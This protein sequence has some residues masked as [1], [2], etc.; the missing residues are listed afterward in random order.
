MLLTL[1][2]ALMRRVRFQLGPGL[3]RPTQLVFVPML[4]LTP[5][6]A[7][8]RWW[9]SGRSSA[10]CPSSSRRRAHPERLLVIVADGWYSVG[11][12]LVIA[13]L[14]GGAAHDATWGV[15]RARAGG[16]DRLRPRRL[17]AAR[18]VRRGDLARRAAAGA[19]ARLPD[20]RAR[21]PRSATSPCSPSEVHEYAYLLAI[22]PGA[23][24]GLIARERSTRI[25]HELA[26]ERAFRRSTRALDARADGPAPPG[27]PAAAA[28]PPRG[29]DRRPRR[30]TARRSSACCST[31][32]IEAL[33]AD[34][35]RL[36]ELDET[37]R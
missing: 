11:P 35:G 13:T 7:V 8:P 25:A 20:R 15:L 2:Y 12:A 33:Q 24:L 36:S 14:A 1:C 27:R 21:W 9:R 26:L 16:A 28:R 30:R 22:A 34:C 37:A 4:F 32:T 17:D 5:A 23:L 19:R 10:S 6:A 29:R 31:T 3:I 18:M